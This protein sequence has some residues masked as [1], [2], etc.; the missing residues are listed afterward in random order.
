MN[1]KKYLI[2]SVAAGIWIFF[3]GYL[4]NA[5]VLADFWAA[6]TSQGLMRTPGEEIMWAIMLSCLLQGLALGY[7]FTRGYEATGIGEGVR[8]G[9]LIAWFVAAVYLLFYALQPVPFVATA[10]SMVTD[11]IMYVG[12]GIILASLYKR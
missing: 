6:H 12:A 3:Y 5:V 2:A 4:A 8:F 7:I 1:T 10:V 11:G 9:F